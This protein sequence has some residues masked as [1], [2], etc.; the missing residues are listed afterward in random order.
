MAIEVGIIGGSG[1]YDL[2]E[3]HSARDVKVDTPFGPAALVVGMFAGHEVAFV[4]RHGPGHRIGPSRIPAREMIYALKH[5]GVRRVVSVSAVGSLRDRLEPGHLVVPDQMVDW[6]RGTRP[7]SF[8]DDG[9]VV[10]VSMADPYCAELRLALIAAARAAADRP[11]HDNGCYVC[12]EGPQFSTRAESELYRRLGMDVIGM[13]AVPEA[14]LAREAGLCYACL[15]LVTDYDCWHH[16][17]EPVSAGLVAT[18]MAENVSAARAAVTELLDMLP[19]TYGCGCGDS[20]ATALITDKAAMLDGTRERL[21]L[22]VGND[23]ARSGTDVT[24]H[25]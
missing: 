16:D 23:A 19:G 15:A 20:L 8:F 21:R 13:T 4:S 18:R 22:L 2:H 24:G 6:T 14:S 1:L 7:R 25:G 11:V 12:I 5:L 17:D 3:P 10:H 9:L